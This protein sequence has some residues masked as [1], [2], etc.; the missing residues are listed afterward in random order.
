MEIHSML[1]KRFFCNGEMFWERLNSNFME[2]KEN[3]YELKISKKY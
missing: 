1:Q 2:W 3:E